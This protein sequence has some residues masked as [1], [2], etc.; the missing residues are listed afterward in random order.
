MV[1]PQVGIANVHVPAAAS[2]GAKASASIVAKAAAIPVLTAFFANPPIVI[3][4]SSVIMSVP[5]LCSRSADE[6]F[7]QRFFDDVTGNVTE[8]IPG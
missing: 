4:V 5:P 2:D 8:E 3:I 1:Q 7:F 6:G